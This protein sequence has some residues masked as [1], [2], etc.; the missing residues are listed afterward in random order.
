MKEKIP[1]E[2]AQEYLKNIHE[3]IDQGGTKGLCIQLNYILENAKGWRGEEAKE[4][5]KFVKEWVEFKLKEVND[6][7]D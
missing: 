3:A 7:E 1:N 5:K 6:Q 2:Y 4:I